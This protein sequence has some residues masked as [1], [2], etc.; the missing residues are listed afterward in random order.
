ML[1][2]A[3]GRVRVSMNYLPIYLSI[4]QSIDPSIHPSPES[5]SLGRKE[6]MDSIV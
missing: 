2:E 3:N 5:S 4:S 6:A 1:S